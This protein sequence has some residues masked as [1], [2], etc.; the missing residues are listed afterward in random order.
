MVLTG[1][2]RVADGKPKLLRGTWKRV[3]GG[4]RETAETSSDDG[5]TWKPL[6]DIVFR[7][8]KP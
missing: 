7:S 8:R 6:F 2:D 3:E 4:V 5:K 1:I